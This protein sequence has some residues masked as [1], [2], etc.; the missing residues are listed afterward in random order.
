MAFAIEDR[1]LVRQAVFDGQL[2]VEHIT[3]DDIYEMED[4]LFEAIAEQRTPFSTWET[5]Q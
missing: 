5:L 2:S 1:D 4:Q 3:M